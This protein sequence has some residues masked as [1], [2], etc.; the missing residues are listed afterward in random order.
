[1]RLSLAGALAAIKLH[2]PVGHI[3]AGV[4]A[5]DMTMP[6]EINRR[7][8][9]SISTLC[10]APTER[11]RRHLVHEGRVE[12]AHLVGDTLVEVCEPFARIAQEQSDVLSRLCLEPHTYGVVTLHRSENVDDPKRAASIVSA[13]T[14]IDCPLV[15]PIHPRTRKM[16]SGFGLLGELE[17]HLTVVSPLGYLD[18]LALLGQAQV[19]LTDSG[20]V[21]QEAS[22]LDV[23]CVTLRYNTE[24]VETIEAGKNALAG[25]ETASIVRVTSEI[26]EDEERRAQ[27]VA[28]LSPFQGGASQRIVDLVEHGANKGT[29]E[30]PASNFLVTGLP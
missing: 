25:A 13:L 4:R 21:Q 1:M 30:V 22:I 28:G 29:L 14:Q 19:V 10:L 6:E 26:L 2:I 17:N 12:S 23:P 7:M 16:L 20:G 8:V 9:D 3:E 11:A 5:Y 27:M 24:W 15:Y 18:F